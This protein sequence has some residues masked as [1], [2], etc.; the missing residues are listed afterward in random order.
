[1]HGMKDLP[2]VADIRTIGLIVG[3]ELKSRPGAPGTR[4]YDAFV[5]CFGDGLLVRVT[6]DIIALS[7]PLILERDHIETIAA[8]LSKAIRAVA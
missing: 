8:K 1:M 3:I 5:K 7:P 2:N 6:G 4:G